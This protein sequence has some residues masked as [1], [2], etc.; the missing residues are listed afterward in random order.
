MVNAST[1][2]RSPLTVGPSMTVKAEKHMD[3]EID[4]LFTLNLYA[5]MDL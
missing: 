4:A 3:G 5:Y 2:R 1:T